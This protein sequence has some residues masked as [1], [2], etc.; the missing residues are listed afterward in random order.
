[1]IAPPRVLRSGAASGDRAPR[2][3]GA[4]GARPEAAAAPPEFRAA[5]VIPARDGLP[6]VLDAVA[7]AL[8]QTLAPAEVVVVD[9]ASSDG[10]A[11]ALE[12]RF[13][14][15]VRVVRGR[16]GS[17]AAARNA[18]WQAARAPWVAF[19]DAD[20]L[21]FPDK[22]AVA[23]TA[24]TRSPEALW[25]FSDGR[26]LT[27]EG[28]LKPS[29]FELCA[30]LAEPYLGSPLA[31]LFEVNFVLTSSVVARRDAIE[32]LHGFREDMSHAE[33]LDL[34]IRLAR[35]GPAAASA[36]A[37]VRYQ[38]RPGGLTRQLEARLDG[39]ARLFLRLA[40]D[41][42]LAGALR[43][44]ARGR[45]ALAHFKLAMA[46]LREERP[47]ECRRLLRLGW[48]FPERVLAVA[49]AYA[50]SLLPGAWRAGLRRRRWAREQF[51]APLSRHR[52]V[53]LRSAETP[54]A[55]A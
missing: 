52:R 21:W 46:A 14:E 53:V 37:L 18:G 22:L 35:R 8:D 1:M 42:T 12:R 32:A 41:P 30:D 27:L 3:D 36:R 25:F 51:A 47:A 13:G 43:R 50:A 10:T 15:R 17:A 28:E 38:H 34:W 54:G 49:V 7:S 19:L 11:E 2:I 24:L 33:D 31:Q 55:R 48:L 29:W 39:S 5:A 40:A 26:F 23:A 16:F 6:D 20:D 9:D 45:A 44:R 4:A